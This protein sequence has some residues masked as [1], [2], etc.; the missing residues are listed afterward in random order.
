MG[1]YNGLLNLKHTQYIDGTTCKNYNEQHRYL[2][3]GIDEEGL[4][5]T[6]ILDNNERDFLMIN[7][8]A[9]K[10]FNECCMLLPPLVM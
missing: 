2:D 6:D 10:Q 3:K 8:F 7:Q 1:E 4:L 9:K 5:T